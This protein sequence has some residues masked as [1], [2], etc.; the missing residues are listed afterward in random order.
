MKIRKLKKSLS[1]VFLSKIYFKS[2]FFIVQKE[3][4][5]MDFFY[6][7]TFLK[8]LSKIFLFKSV[9]N[10]KTFK[11]PL[12]IKFFDSFK[13][14]HKNSSKN[15]EFIFLSFR[16]FFLKTECSILKNSIHSINSFKHLEF[17]FKKDYFLLSNIEMLK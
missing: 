4:K 15:S 2:A 5:S 11:H 14:L 6:S 3:K 1:A 7:H 13:E 8:V 9:L 17:F 16:E 10:L 12:Y